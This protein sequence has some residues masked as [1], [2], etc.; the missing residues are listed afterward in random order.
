MDIAVVLRRA[1]EERGYRC[2]AL[3]PEIVTKLPEVSDSISEMHDQ[4]I[5]AET[6]CLGVCL[7]TSDEQ[8]LESNLVDCIRAG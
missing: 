6:R 3:E 5:T 8:I 1:H 7:L 4:M 2:P